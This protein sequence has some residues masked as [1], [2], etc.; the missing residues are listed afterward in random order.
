METQM[1]K[2][3]FNQYRWVV[4]ALMFLCFLFTFVTRFAWPPLIPVIVPA[5]GMKMTQAGAFMSAFYFGYVVTQ[6]P[7]GVLADRFG[8]RLILAISLILEGVSTFGMGYMQGYDTG[9]WLR[10]VTGLGAGAV[11]AACSRALMEWFPA[12]ERGIAFGIMLAAPS[13]GIVLSN[14]IVPAL[15]QAFGWQGAFKSIGIA[16]VLLGIAIYFLVRTTDEPKGEK[17][18]LGGFKV[19]FGNRD[20]LLT[21]SA[22][23]C[24][25]WVELGTATWANAY[26]KKLGF[27]LADAGLVMILYGI[28]GVI[29]PMVSG[30]LSDRM[31]NRKKLLILSYVA[32]IPLTVY[33]GYQTTL[34]MLCIVGF[35][36]GFC[37]YMANPQL[38]ILISEFAGKEWA[39]TANGISNFIFQLASMIGP[40]IL[41]FSIDATGSFNT[42]WWMMAA[43]PL[44]GILLLL[45]VGRKSQTAAVN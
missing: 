29:A 18:M 3:E 21:A 30:Y 28:G 20:I 23:F 1:K 2:D 44:V 6:I 5:L 14:Y 34:S 38:T 33:F 36:F 13:G 41:G 45:P 37:S 19:V 9:F 43:G 7:A 26:I 15:N 27:S 11:F 25:M 24:L 10:A 4:L 16:T 8:V 39:A 42:V 40:V 17:S 35:A 12:K 31:G 22:G 32:I